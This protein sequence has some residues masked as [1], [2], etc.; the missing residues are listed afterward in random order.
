[1]DTRTLPDDLVQARRAFT[2]TYQDLAAPRPSQDRTALRRR[3]LRLS[4]WIHWH[5][6]WTSP[7]GP[8]DRARLREAA[9]AWPD[10][11]GLDR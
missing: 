11:D 10:R 4:V 3:L 5:P 9:R 8:A 7:A 6:Y 1:M 2:A